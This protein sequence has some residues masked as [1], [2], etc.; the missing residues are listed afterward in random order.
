MKYHHW[1]TLYGDQEMP[2]DEELHANLEEEAAMHEEKKD[3]Q[4]RYA[5]KAKLRGTRPDMIIADDLEEPR[6]PIDV[7]D[8]R[9]VMLDM[10]KR[11]H[12]AAGLDPPIPHS[13][14]TDDARD[15]LKPTNPKDLVATT[16][17]DLSLFP[18][19]AV[20]HGALALMEGHL[21][22]GAYNWRVGG[23][24]ISVYLAALRRHIAKFENGEWEDARTGVPH[25]S[26]AL[27]CIAILIDGFEVDCIKDDRP[28]K[29]PDIAGMYDELEEKVK[30]LIATF[31]PEN[32][33]GR[34]TEGQHGEQNRTKALSDSVGCRGTIQTGR[35]SK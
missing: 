24:L 34:Y 4:S 30:H 3:R 7:D 16:K 6:K 5:E 21:K 2:N 28:P 20:A 27:A 14:L 35:G 9:R 25:L 31:P 29:H 23:I 22:Y 12:E 1:L 32:S 10:D 19:T 13:I 26:N 8:V 33:P 15:A 18:H 11:M 17:I